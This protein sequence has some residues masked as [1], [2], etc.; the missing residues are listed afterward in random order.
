MSNVSSE[1][2]AADSFAPN[3][4][5]TVRYAER[6]TYDRS[7][8][9]AILDEA[10][11]CHVGF[12]SRGRTVVIPLLH[13]RVGDDLLLHGSPATRLFRTLK[14]APE[15]CV[16]V[17]LLDGLV[18]ARS[19]FHHSANYR[20]AVVFGR[21][22]V[23]D[24]LDAKFAALD[25]FTDKLVPE[26]RAHLRTMTGKEVRGTSVFRLAITEASAKIRSGPPGDEE[27]DYELPIWAG[28]VPLRTGFADPIPDPR[29]L[30]DLTVPAHVA[31]MISERGAGSEQVG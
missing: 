6:A 3:E 10:L 31:S 19:A 28:V 13:A 5:T 4:H 18:L 17:T 22:E 8:V 27:A 7:V 26:R 11:L 21:P 12:V 25:A 15:I 23:V 2:T 20:S 9:H 14:P 1:S 30:S 16:T 29:N 24:D